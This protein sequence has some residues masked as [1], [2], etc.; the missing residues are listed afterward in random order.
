[1]YVQYRHLNTAL[2][3]WEAW[4]KY[5]TERPVATRFLGRRCKDD[6]TTKVA[7]IRM[8]RESLVGLAYL[9]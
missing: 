6:L 5:T 2:N 8:L 3:A 4:S 7:L 1:M 9:F